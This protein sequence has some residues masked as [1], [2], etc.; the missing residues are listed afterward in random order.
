SAVAVGGCPAGRTAGDAESAP[1]FPYSRTVSHGLVCL[2]Q[3]VA[4]PLAALA[5][6]NEYANGGITATLLAVPRRGV[7]LAA[8][9]AVTAGLS[10]TAGAGTAALGLGV[11]WLLV[12]GHVS[13][14]PG[15]AAHTVLGAG[16]CMALLAVLFTGLGTALRG[17]AGT[18]AAGFLLLLGLPLVLQLS[19]T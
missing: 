7:L 9:T 12:G 4:L 13:P 19:Q 8:R 10:F 5:A 17:T 18:L 2:G 6:T 15:R 3:F 11:L 16:V 1:G 14:D